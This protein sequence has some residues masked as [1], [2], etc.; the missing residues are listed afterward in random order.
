MRTVCHVLWFPALL[1]TLLPHS[2]MRHPHAEAQNHL[3]T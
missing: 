2:P 1:L 3:G